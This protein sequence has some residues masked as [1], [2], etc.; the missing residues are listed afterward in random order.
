MRQVV[1][2]SMSIVFRRN[3]KSI[4]IYD[5]KSRKF[6]QMVTQLLDSQ[7]FVQ[8]NKE[9]PFERRIIQLKPNE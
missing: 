1:S 5:N 4:T 8:W 6:Q 3:K 7:R 2:D 9:L